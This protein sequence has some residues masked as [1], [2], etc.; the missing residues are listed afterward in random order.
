SY[1]LREIVITNH[2]TC[3]IT[4]KL[5]DVSTVIP[6]GTLEDKNGWRVVVTKY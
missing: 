1:E 5:Y 2:E 4:Q 6:N 3:E